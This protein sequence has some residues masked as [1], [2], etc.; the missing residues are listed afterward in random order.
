M[1]DTLID[2]GMRRKFKKLLMATFA[3][4][5]LPTLAAGVRS[6]LAVIGKIAARNLTTLVPGAGSPFP[7]VGEV[8]WVGFLVAATVAGAVLVLRH[9]VSPCDGLAGC[10][11]LRLTL[12]PNTRTLA[13]LNGF[14]LNR[15]VARNT[16]GHNIG[17]TATVRGLARVEAS[18]GNR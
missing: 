11:D 13:L 2:R 1:D 4:A 14:A 7:V 18:T 6:P 16:C 12:V 8:A 15:R 9:V 3:V 10:M 5:V 17:A